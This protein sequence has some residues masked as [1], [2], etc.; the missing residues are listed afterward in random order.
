MTHE[1]I[2]LPELL[3]PA[4]SAE[5]F[6]AAISAGADAVYFGGERFSARARAKNLTPDE[7]RQCLRECRARGVRAYAAINTRLRDSEIPDAVEAAWDMLTAGTDALIVADP[8]LV[9]ELRRTFPEAVLHAS[10][11]ITGTSAAD[12][13]VLAEM[14]F[15]RMVCP[16]ELSLEEVQ[17]LV[18]ESPIGIEMFIHGAHCV[19]VSGQCSMS[20]VM[21]GRSGNRG[22]CAGPCRLPFGAGIGSGDGRRPSAF[23]LSLKDMCLAGHVREII[24]SGVESLKIEGRLKGPEY[25]YGVVSIYRRLLDERRDATPD[26]TA[27]LSEYFSRDGFSDGY[28]RGRYGSMLGTRKDSEIRQD[29]ERFPVPAAE[30]IPVKG[31][32]RLHC[33]EKATLTLTSPTASATVI[34]EVLAPAMGNPPSDESLRKSVSKLGQTPFVMESLTVDTDGICGIA[35]SALNQLRREAADML[36]APPA[37]VRSDAPAEE[38]DD[39][40]SPDKAIRAVTLTSADQLTPSVTDY[41]D[42]IYVPMGDFAESAA[43]HNKVGV[44]L[45]DVLYSGLIDEVKRTA[46]RAAKEGR[47]VLVHTLGELAIAREAGAT[48]VCSHRFVVYNSG[49]AR[50]LREMGAAAVTVSPEIPAMAARSIGKAASAAVLAGGR[51]P[52]M[53]CRRCPI[54]DGGRNCPHRRIGGYDGKTKPG[55][56]R[57]H[58]TD[59]TGATLP[60]VGDRYCMT[61][62]YN[63]VPTYT[64]LTPADAARNG[65][66]VMMHTFAAESAEECDKAVKLMRDGRT[67]K[68]YRKLK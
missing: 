2:V 26:E 31:S 10:T 34:G 54:S 14:G 32:L 61:T 46:A 20:Y 36:C 49:T 6:A 59:R 21:G 62:V 16:R 11:Q 19:S 1:N 58:L 28:L 51:M 4:G 25:T 40:P 12:A 35:A 37:V 8:G 13:A 53:L 43:W 63:S 7:V 22:D 57:G 15:S 66:A 65:I 39:V 9:R 60:A 30:K 33:G 18:K 38:P 64:D 23:V 68:E 45:P 50:T 67:P 24:D 41:F 17:T 47:R 44:S 48:A 29:H 3:A 27:M 42:E 5:S 55:I 52:L 56:C